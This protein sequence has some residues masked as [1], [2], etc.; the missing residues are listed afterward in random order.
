MLA[1]VK[2]LVEVVATLEVPVI[3]TLEA[4]ER[5]FLDGMLGAF[6]YQKVAGSKDSLVVFFTFFKKKL[7]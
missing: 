3:L 5:C 6:S 4:V 7:L 2:V 1:M